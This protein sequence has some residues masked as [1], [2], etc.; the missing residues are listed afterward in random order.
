VAQDYYRER[1]EWSER[2]H[3]LLARYLTPFVRILGGTWRGVVYYVDGFAGPGIY[4]DG[5]EGSPLLAA[6]HATRLREQGKY[7]GLRCINIE[8][9]PRH[10]ANLEASTKAYAQVVQ[11]YQGTFGQ[12]IGDVLQTIAG[13][14]ALFFLDPFGVKGMEWRHVEPI[15]N[16]ADPT[17]ILL[18]FD[19]STIARLAGSASSSAR[20]AAAKVHR[21]TEI[22]GVDGPEEW[23]REWRRGQTA[24]ERALNMLRLYL[25]RLRSSINMGAGSFAAGYSIRDVEGRHKYYIAFA[26]RHQKAAV[27]MSNT[28]HEV[29]AT[30][31]QE[32]QEYRKQKTLQPTL[33]GMVPSEEEI[34][35]EKVRR[36][37]EDLAQRFAGQT[38]SRLW[39]HARILDKWFGR[40]KRTHLTRALEELEGEGLVS[41]DGPRSNDSTLFSFKRGPK[42]G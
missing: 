25:R 7:Y 13:Y 3:R 8:L 30:Y 1:K 12:H 9:S 16:R 20:Q 14:P 41:R 36:V 27:L 2:K 34:F 26:S 28:I 31:E 18:R 38:I 29:E 42:M 10:H 21:L 35:R 11:N 5:C 22:Y 4:A 37:K 24:H 19:S 15:L 39:L 33:P 6:Q 17:D 32:V 40:I 23:I